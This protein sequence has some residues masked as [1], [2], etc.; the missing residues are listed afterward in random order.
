MIGLFGKGSE[1]KL[2]TLIRRA[3]FVPAKITI[4]ATQVIS[5]TSMGE[6]ATGVTCTCHYFQAC[7]VPVYSPFS[8]GIMTR[9]RSYAFTPCGLLLECKTLGVTVHHTY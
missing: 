1:E 8:W 3:Q 7:L 4:K 5:G 9:N 6:Q 2:A